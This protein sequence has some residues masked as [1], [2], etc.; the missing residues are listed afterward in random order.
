MSDELSRSSTDEGGKRAD[1]PA[2]PLRLPARTANARSIRVFLFAAVFSL[3]LI[4][5][6]FGWGGYLVKSIIYPRLYPGLTNSD[7]L[8]PE[9]LHELLQGRDRATFVAAILFA[10]IPITLA[11]IFVRRMTAGIRRAGELGPSGSQ[12]VTTYLRIPNQATR[13]RVRV[14]GLSS[15]SLGWLVS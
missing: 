14:S 7:V 8:S 1:Q 10:A 12:R 15:R 2:S 6:F 13:K 9:E 4:P 3:F 5:V 11:G